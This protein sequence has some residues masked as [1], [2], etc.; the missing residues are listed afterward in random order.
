MKR[1]LVVNIPDEPMKFSNQFTCF[2]SLLAIALLVVVWGILPVDLHA[3]E[4]NEAQQRPVVAQRL[5]SSL[6]EAVKALQAATETKIK[7]P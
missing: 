5:F 1:A 7:R 4:S 3:A 2:T 6:D